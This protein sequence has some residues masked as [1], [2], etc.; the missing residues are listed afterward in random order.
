MRTRL[1]L[2]T[3]SGS[4]QRGLPLLQVFD[5]ESQQLGPAQVAADEQREDG[6]V[7][8]TG[9]SL[10]NGAVEQIVGLFFGRSTPQ[11]GAVAD[12]AGNPAHCRGRI[13]QAV[14]SALNIS[15]GAG[16]QQRFPW[17]AYPVQLAPAVSL[18]AFLLAHRAF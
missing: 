7:T 10:R 15:Q 13:E 12:D 8:L 2:P 14:D 18:P 3:K 1:P 11:P 16:D 5:F 4:I 6:E 9:H 17:P